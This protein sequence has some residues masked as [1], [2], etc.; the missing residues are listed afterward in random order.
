MCFRHPYREAAAIAEQ[1]FF[2]I[3]RRNVT[4]Q[5]DSVLLGFSTENPEYSKQKSLA[6]GKLRWILLVTMRVLNSDEETQ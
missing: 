1:I 6:E 2:Y 4:V 3:Y 5:R